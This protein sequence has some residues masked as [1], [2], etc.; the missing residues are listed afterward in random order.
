MSHKILLDDIQ[1]SARTIEADYDIHIEN[2][3]DELRQRFEE[4]KQIKNILN[5]LNKC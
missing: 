4:M 2:R 3:A 5:P 1:Q